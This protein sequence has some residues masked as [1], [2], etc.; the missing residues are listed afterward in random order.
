MAVATPPTA[1]PTAPGAGSGAGAA[2]LLFVFLSE[3]LDRPVEDSLGASLGRLED[4]TIAGGDPFP[5]VRHCVIRQ[6][7]PNRL[8]LLAR[9]NDVAQF[10]GGR[11]RLAVPAAQLTPAAP[12]A[13]RELRLRQH[14]LDK[15]VVDTGG[16]K[17]VRV[18]DVQ[19]LASHSELRT[20][21]VDVGF[22][23]LVRRLGVEPAIDTLVRRLSPRA[24]YLAS[25][26]LIS[27]RH[28]E[29]LSPGESP[30]AIH[31]SLSRAQ[32]HQAHPV[33]IAELLTEL[34][35]IRRLRLFRALDPETGARALAEVPTEIQ[36][37]L[38]EMMPRHEAADVLERMSPDEAA[39]LL[40][41]LP[42]ERRL[43]LLAHM[44]R[45]EASDVEGL[46][47]HPEGTAGSLMTTD[48][49]TLRDD[50]TI[51]EALERLRGLA[52]DAE[53]IYYVYVVDPAGVLVGVLSLRALITEPPGVPISQ[54]MLRR[55]VSVEADDSLAECASLVAKYNLLALPVLRPDHTMLGVITVDDVLGEVLEQAWTRKFAR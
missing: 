52:P 39:D 38:L 46:L 10:R 15:Q 51:G 28:V 17:I 5:R 48:F 31:L 54:V 8:R 26:N 21:H 7:W 41:E 4:L 40:A 45:E 44:E 16:L 2:T 9:W 53:T 55:P 13:L 36:A 47:A 11:I 22:R 50:L 49:V 33:D 25:D 42:E 29:T 35:P 37:R 12:E 43:E 30:H 18:N 6:G 34:D 14:V 1:R 19:F 20:V 32:V 24:R 27:W 3:L 23:G